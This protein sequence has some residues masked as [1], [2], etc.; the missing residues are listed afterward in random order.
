MCQTDCKHFR[1]ENH[2][3]RPKAPVDISR[4]SGKMMGA[5]PKYRIMLTQNAE[6]RALARGGLPGR[7]RSRGRFSVSAQQATTGQRFFC[8]FNGR[9]FLDHSSVRWQ[10]PIRVLPTAQCVCLP[11]VTRR[12]EDKMSSATESVRTDA[13]LAFVPHVPTP[14]KIARRCAEIRRTWDATT[15]RSRGRGTRKAYRLP[16]C[17]APKG[18]SLRKGGVL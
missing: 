8:A 6:I 1:L 2:D 17:T 4:D 14:D 13:K 10:G 18:E 7:Q 15:R 11:A 12:R 3:S 5:K 9:P 16:V